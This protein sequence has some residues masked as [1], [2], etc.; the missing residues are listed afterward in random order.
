M[1][2]VIPFLLKT[3]FLPS[4]R[5]PQYPNG[6]ELFTTRTPPYYW[7]WVGRAVYNL[8]FRILQTNFIKQFYVI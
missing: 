8:I 1:E 7:P 6:T 3:Y 4:L 5:T 2:N